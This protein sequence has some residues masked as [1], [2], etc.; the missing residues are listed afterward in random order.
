[1]GQGSKA[2]AGSAGTGL[3]AGGV[4]A[5]GTGTGGALGSSGG[6]YQTPG[7]EEAENTAGY[8]SGLP[9]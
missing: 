7:S 4:G 9:A 5:G 8:A 3:G 6:N 2:A 1:M